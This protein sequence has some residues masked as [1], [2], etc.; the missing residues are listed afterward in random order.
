MSVNQD[1]PSKSLLTVHKFGEASHPN[2]S[3]PSQPIWAACISHIF[4]DV[5]RRFTFLSSHRNNSLTIPIQLGR[6]NNEDHLLASSSQPLSRHA[7]THGNHQPGGQNH[8]FTEVDGTVGPMGETYVIQ[9]TWMTRWT[10]SKSI[11][12]RIRPHPHPPGTTRMTHDC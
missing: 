1:N 9:A 4:V 2:V 6:S 10:K 3:D 11:S 5:F 12:F 7:R 8:G